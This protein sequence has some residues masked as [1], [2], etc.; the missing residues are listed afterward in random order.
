MPN[1]V[2]SI[3]GLD[4]F[5]L[6]FISSL[7][8]LAVFVAIYVRVTPYRE[9]ALIRDGNLAA[10]ASLS[11]ALLGFIVPLASAVAHSVALWDM[12]LWGIIAMAAQLLAYGAVRLIMPTIAS[13]IPAGK[14]AP[15]A[16]LGV[17]S[18]GVGILNAA[19][20]TY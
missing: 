10:T 18:L 14:I 15:G 6:Y 3:G 4:D 8:L 7:A 5:L 13:D 2:E 19:S 9:F 11:G 17:L 12:A 1:F 16:F 20:M